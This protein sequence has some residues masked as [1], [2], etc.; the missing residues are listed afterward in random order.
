[1]NVQEEMIVRGQ[2]IWR[3]TRLASDEKVLG[4]LNGQKMN[5]S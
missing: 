1:L 4:P 2:S 3:V 5:M